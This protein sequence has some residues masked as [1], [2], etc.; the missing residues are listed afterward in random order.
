MAA[1]VVGDP[2]PDERLGLLAAADRASVACASTDERGLGPDYEPVGFG[3]QLL[4]EQLLAIATGRDVGTDRSGSAATSAV[5]SAIVASGDGGVEPV[6]TRSCG[7]CLPTVASGETAPSTA[8]WRGRGPPSWAT[9][10]APAQPPPH[11][12]DRCPRSVRGGRPGRSPP[13]HRR[14]ARCNSR[15]VASPPRPSTQTRSFSTPSSRTLCR[16]DNPSDPCSG[17]AR[18]QFS[19]KSTTTAAR[20]IASTPTSPP[21]PG[22]SASANSSATRSRCMSALRSATASTPDSWRASRSHPSRRS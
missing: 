5:A 22:S 4:T 16:H 9:R 20:S 6:G 13:G 11:N 1:P 15:R 14:R 3:K 8:V 19:A 17:S 2:C 10:R 18:Q 21:A 12:S 7:H